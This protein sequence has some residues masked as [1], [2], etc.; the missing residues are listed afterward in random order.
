MKILHFKYYMFAD[1][2]VLSARE[3]KCYF[4]SVY[5]TGNIFLPNILTICLIFRHILLY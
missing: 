5:I 4:F 3:L 1:I 2:V